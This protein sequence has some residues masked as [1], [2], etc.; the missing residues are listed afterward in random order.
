MRSHTDHWRERWDR[1][2]RDT[3][4][5]YHTR[6]IH[7]KKNVRGADI[8]DLQHST[9]DGY[10]VRSAILDFALT[11]ARLYQLTT[12]DRQE[13]ENLVGQLITASPF[14][15]KAQQQAAARNWHRL[16]R[17]AFLSALDYSNSKTKQ[18]LQQ[19]QTFIDSSN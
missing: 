8:N 1:D 5:A 6:V 11:K 18:T 4:I 13:L 7:E 9:I 19:L 14:D 3:L 17:D 12:R 15:N 10:A 16:H 2:L